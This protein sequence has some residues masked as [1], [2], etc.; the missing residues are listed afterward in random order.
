MRLAM[1]EYNMGICCFMIFI[2]MIFCAI[3][4]CLFAIITGKDNDKR[5]DKDVLCGHRSNNNSNN[6]IDRDNRWN[7][8]NNPRTE[9]E[10]VED[11]IICH[12]LGLF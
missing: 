10:V 7:Q 1:L 2:G 6:V 12:M 4:I 9:D 3:L 11:L 5:I 8:R